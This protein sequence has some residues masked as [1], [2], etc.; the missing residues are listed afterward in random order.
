MIVYGTSKGIVLK[1]GS[2]RN[3]VCPEC[4]TDTS[5]DYIVFGRYA[6]LYWIPF[7]PIGKTEIGICKT[8][9]TD[10]E[11]KNF[12]EPIKK[13]FDREK[14]NGR[15]R[16]PIWFFSG[17]IL[18]ASLISFGVYSSNESDQ[19]EKAY[20]EN[21]KAGDVYLTTADAGFYSTYKVSQV[22]KDSLYVFA[23]DLQTDKQSSIYKIDTPE[24]YKEVYAFSRKDL[25]KMYQ[26][27]EI[28][29]INRP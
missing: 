26:N 15:A 9:S 29:E 11:V 13:K 8:C 5:M 1:K 14:E 17:L 19:L 25:E 18:V 12:R 28:F 24:H 4:Q 16:T 21:P 23:N 3:I 20:I 6:H 7:F 2:V 22:R 10:F 27:G